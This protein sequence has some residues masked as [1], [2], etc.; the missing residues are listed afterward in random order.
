M[1]QKAP[2]PKPR[3]RASRRGQNSD[4][5]LTKIDL[6]KLIVLVPAMAV[7]VVAMQVPVLT[8]VGSP[9]FAASFVP[10]PADAF[11]TYSPSETWLWKG[12]VL[13]AVTH[14]GYLIFRLVRWLGA[15]FSDFLFPLLLVPL[16]LFAAYIGAMMCRIDLLHLINQN[17]GKP[18]V[19]E[20]VLVG[21]RTACFR[22][23]GY[24]SRHNSIFSRGESR[25]HSE[26]LFRTQ[27]DTLYFRGPSLLSGPIGRLNSGDVAKLEV[28]KSFLGTSLVWVY[29]IGASGGPASGAAELL[30]WRRLESMNRPTSPWS[31]PELVDR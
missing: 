4:A 6:L 21:T 7:V 26:I 13:L 25:C 20:A 3:G 29:P 30:D 24:N 17:F 16:G 10:A 12:L 28:C 23:T 15:H 8:L 11:S 27:S 9:F 19:V 2:S 18:E 1:M 31:V 22:F 5:P 14:C